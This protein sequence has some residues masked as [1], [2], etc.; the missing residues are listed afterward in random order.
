MRGEIVQAGARGIWR[1]DWVV[2]VVSTE[3]RSV[4]AEVDW[5]GGGRGGGVGGGGGGEGRGG[6]VGGGGGGERGGE[7][8]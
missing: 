5:G 6:G 4:G 2:E 8:I 3:R 1:L 7:R